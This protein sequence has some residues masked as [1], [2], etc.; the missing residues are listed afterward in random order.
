[1]LRN[2]ADLI[3]LGYMFII[4]SLLIVQWYLSSF[5]WL[6]YSCT[7]LMMPTTF[8][9]AHNHNHLSMW[10]SRILNS[11][12]DFWQVAFYGYP[13]FVWIPTHNLNHHKYIN[14]K[15]DYTITY[16]FKNNNNLL[17]LLAYP[18]ISSF[19]QSEAIKNYLRKQWKVNSK[20]FYYCI[21]QYVFLIFYLISFFFL[22]AQK[23][24][25]YILIPQVSCLFSVL[26]INY[27]QH[28]H[29][30]ENSKYNNSRNFGGLGNKFMLNN[31]LHTAHHKKMSSHWSEL[32]KIHK[33]LETKIDKSLLERSIIWYLLRV[34]ILS[35][36]I[37][38]FRSKSLRQ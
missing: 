7:I 27:I 9:M 12:T 36:F 10:R 20:R 15:G 11:L 19:Y 29:T 35:I 13:V 32:P 3:S 30:D 18:F 24:L 31:G 1:M 5:N 26:V 14:K 25:L 8:V 23:A 2:K 22:D 4:T 33:N 17:T 28:V 16:R 34:Y 38:K 6:L 37:P 21:A